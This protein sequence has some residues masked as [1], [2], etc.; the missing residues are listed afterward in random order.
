MLCLFRLTKSVFFYYI[1]NKTEQIVQYLVTSFK[2][3]CKRSLKLSKTL[4]VPTTISVVPKITGTIR[5]VPFCDHI[6]T[7]TAFL[8]NELKIKLNRHRA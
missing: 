3:Y 8:T 4:K 6:E 1:I 2:N 5:N 7:H